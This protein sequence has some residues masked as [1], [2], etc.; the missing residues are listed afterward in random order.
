MSQV[1]RSGTT[2]RPRCTCQHIAHTLSP[3]PPCSVH[4]QVDTQHRH[5]LCCVYQQGKVHSRS[6]RHLVRFQLGTCRN[7]RRHQRCLR[8]RRT[9][10]CLARHPRSL[11]SLRIPTAPVAGRLLGVRACVGSDLAACTASFT[12]SRHSLL[13]HAGCCSVALC[14]SFELLD[15]LFSA[16]IGPPPS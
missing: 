9:A 1:H 3:H 14:D 7:H 10:P 16:K 4:T 6:P 15:E 5:L 13:S 8:G 2:N 11:T 12:A